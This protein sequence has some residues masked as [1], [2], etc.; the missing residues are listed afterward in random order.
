MS[1]QEKEKGP[2]KHHRY[3]SDMTRKEKREIE[4]EKLSTMS[5]GGKLGYIWT[6]YKGAMAAILGVI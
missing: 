1:R 6:Y 3:E 2:A 4:K 5:I